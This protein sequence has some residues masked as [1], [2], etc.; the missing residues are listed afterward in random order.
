MNQELDA[1]LAELKAQRNH[2][3]DL[4]AN[5]GGRIA[6][7]TATLADVQQRIAELEK[8][9]PRTSELV[10]GHGNVRVGD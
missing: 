10:V 2:A 9:Q 5:A 1:M 8:K 3:L 4:L 7:L 6:V